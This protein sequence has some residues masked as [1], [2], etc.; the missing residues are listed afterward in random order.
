MGIFGLCRSSR[1]VVSFSVA[2]HV[3]VLFQ[4]DLII[5]PPCVTGHPTWWD[6]TDTPQHNKRNNGLE[7]YRLSE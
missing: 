5:V 1:A 7:T 4:N 3:N 6:A 2:Q